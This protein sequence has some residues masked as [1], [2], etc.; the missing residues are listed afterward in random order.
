MEHVTNGYCGECEKD[1]KHQEIVYYTWYE[2]D[3]FCKDCKE[4]IHERVLNRKYLDW[5]KRTNII[6]QSDNNY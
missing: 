5:Q 3:Y 2:N 1:F 4:K 6:D